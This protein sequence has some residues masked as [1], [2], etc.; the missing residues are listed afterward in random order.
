[1]C[2]SSWEC[3]PRDGCVIFVRLQMFGSFPTAG[4]LKEERGK[5]GGVAQCA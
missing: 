5:K 2:R 1:M 3:L 4:D